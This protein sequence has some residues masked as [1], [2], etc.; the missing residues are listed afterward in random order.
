MTAEELRAARLLL[1]MTEGQAARF[2]GVITR[3]W[4]RWEAGERPVPNSVARLF[5]V[6][7][8]I[9][10]IRDLLENYDAA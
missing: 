4:R 1:G 10:A 6:A 5:Y 7:L 8:R 9:P 3:L 2:A